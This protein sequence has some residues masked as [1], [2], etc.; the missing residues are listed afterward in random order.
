MKEI[1]INYDVVYMLSHSCV[2]LFENLQTVAYQAPL[3]KGFPRQE[4]WVGYHALL[5]GVFRN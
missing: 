1:G 5:P 2:L 3:S 4:Y